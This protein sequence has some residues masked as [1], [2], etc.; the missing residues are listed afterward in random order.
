MNKAGST[1]RIFPGWVDALETNMLDYMAYYARHLPTMEVIDEKGL[2]IINSGVP[3]VLFNYICRARLTEAE[4][5]Q[6][7]I[8][9]AVRY[10]RERDLPFSWWI[11]PSTLPKQLP[12]MLEQN[13]LKASSQIYEGMVMPLEQLPE[14]PSPEDLVIRSASND[15]ELND[16]ADVAAEAF[17]VPQ[18]VM[19]SYYGQAGELSFSKHHPIRLYIGYWQGQPSVTCILYKADK[20]AGIYSVATVPKARR[21]GFGTALTLSALRDA[22]EEGMLMAG[23]QATEK[24]KSV[25]ERIGFVR[26]CTFF[27]YV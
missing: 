22:R 12:K 23:L 9:Q 13:G 5:V 11:S 20:M 17:Q 6:N 16:F 27:E 1:E 3:S 2:Q 18:E 7:R 14:Q 24:G 26:C 8:E 4:G 25:Y 21:R 19:R 10:F 15:E